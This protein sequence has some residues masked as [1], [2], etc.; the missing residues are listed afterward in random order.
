MQVRLGTHL[1]SGERVAIKVIDKTRLTDPVDRKRVAREI[2]VLKK[3]NQVS[4]C[5]SL[6]SS[7]HLL[8]RQQLGLLNRSFSKLGQA[9]EP[10]RR[11]VTCCD[12]E[13]GLLDTPCCSEFGT[14]VTFAQR[15]TFDAQFLLSA[16]VRT[17]LPQD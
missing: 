7:A 15:N 4:L 1:V 9:R 3:L 17:S 14:Q 11:F 13:P 16:L 12:L 8:E 5:E 6:R 2:R 10:T